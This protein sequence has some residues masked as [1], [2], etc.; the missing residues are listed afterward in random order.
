MK[1]GT[2]FVTASFFIEGAE[3]KGSEFE[4]NQELSGSHHF[5]FCC[6]WREFFKFSF[7]NGTKNHNLSNSIVVYLFINFYSMHSFFA[8]PGRRHARILEKE[9]V[10]QLGLVFR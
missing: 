5:D 2:I 8:L 7:Q 10:S 9:R 3:S 4:A 1:I 6:F